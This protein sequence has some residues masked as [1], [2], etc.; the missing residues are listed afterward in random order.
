[1]VAAETR[2]KMMS[3]GRAYLLADH[4]KFARRTPFRV[5]NT[6]QCKGVIVDRLPH[7]SLAAAWEELGWEIVLAK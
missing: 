3:A 7:R 5:P 6:S 4:T 1:M 2:G